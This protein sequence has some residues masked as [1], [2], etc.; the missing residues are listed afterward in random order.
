[1]KDM[2]S[3]FNLSYRG[4]LG[5][6]D[7]N[8]MIH[9]FQ[10]GYYEVNN[11]DY[12]ISSN[13]YPLP[14]YVLY[15]LENQFL[16]SNQLFNSKLQKDATK[17]KVMEYNEGLVPSAS[18]YGAGIYNI[19]PKGM[20][21]NYFNITLSK[22]PLGSRN[23]NYRMYIKNDYTKGLFKEDTIYNRNDINE[24]NYSPTWIPY[25]N[26]IDILNHFNSNKKIITGIFELLSD[27]D[28]VIQTFHRFPDE[29][30][31]TRSYDFEKDEWTTWAAEVP[32]YL[33]LDKRPLPPYTNHNNTVS[34]GD[35]RVPTSKGLHNNSY[36][37][38]IDIDPTTNISIYDENYVDENIYEG[39]LKDLHS[40]E[41]NIKE[42][43]IDIDSGS[44]T[45]IDPKPIE[46]PKFLVHDEFLKDSKYKL[47]MGLANKYDYL[48]LHHKYKGT[49]TF[50]ELESTV[51]SLYTKSQDAR[52]NF[53]NII[54]NAYTK[55]TQMENDLKNKLSKVDG[56]ADNAFVIYN[57]IDVSKYLFIGE[58]DD[59]GI[60]GN[61]YSNIFP[62]AKVYHG[63][64]KS[65]V[66]FFNP[67]FMNYGPY[68]VNK[69]EYPVIRTI[70]R[71]FVIVNNKNLGQ[72]STAIGL[73]YRSLNYTPLSGGVI[74]GN[75]PTKIGGPTT[76]VAVPKYYDK[77]SSPLRD[78][79]P[80]TFLLRLK[81]SQS[82]W[83]IEYPI[84]AG[85][86]FPRTLLPSGSNAGANINDVANLREEYSGY[87]IEYRNGSDGLDYFI[88]YGTNFAFSN[89]HRGIVMEVLVQE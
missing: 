32:S 33:K 42:R 27:E 17:I 49:I 63:D 18:Y 76:T 79:M 82:S 48:N 20:W 85:E 13:H 39:E 16:I 87:Y 57:V 3:T 68:N 52:N 55:T 1:M 4:E 86:Y 77:E 15:D 44:D 51:E 56:V 19:P 14:N 38:E 28:L 50:K 71:P 10:N 22:R 2:T 64:N 88:F 40:I 59:S 31:W 29:S 70:S 80:V 21:Y 58:N 69:Q 61:Y 46:G 53:K 41:N 35:L 65:Y 25:K 84:I 89:G 9:S 73:T 5:N 81:D 47:K 24:N 7:L 23:I 12:V 72:A 43:L 66:G 60:Y 30:T 67:T 78:T 36:E 45:T 8:T 74:H 26:Q 83:G 75:Y 11:S 34:E 54:N 62:A 6:I 37:V